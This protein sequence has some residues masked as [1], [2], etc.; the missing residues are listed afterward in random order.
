M[1][2]PAVSC[3]WS[4]SSMTSSVVFCAM[5][6]RTA[7][8]ISSGSS[9]RMGA[10]SSEGVICMMSAIWSIGRFARMEAA[11]SGSSSLR[12]S[13]VFS[14]SRSYRVL[15]RIRRSRE[16]R[17]S[18]RLAISAGWKFLT[19]FQSRLREPMLMNF[20]AERITSR[21]ASTFMFLPLKNRLSKYHK[22]RYIANG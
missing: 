18:M 14:L 21:S 22:F 5:A 17:W 16:M 19:R 11:S 6:A 20:R 1:M 10:T 7:S 13:A 3:S 2:R 15:I 12:T 8:F 9:S 4:R